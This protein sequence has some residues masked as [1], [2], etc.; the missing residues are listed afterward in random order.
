MIGPTLTLDLPVL[1]PQ[2]RMV[3]T[4]GGEGDGHEGATHRVV[5]ERIAALLGLPFGGACGEG[6]A[7]GGSYLV[8]RAPLCGPLAALRHGIEGEHDLLGSWVHEA[9]MATKAIVHPLVSDEAQAPAG[10]PRLLAR[11]AMAL[12]LRGRTAFCAEDALEAGRE[13]L[14]L[15]PVRLKPAGADGG[16]GQTVVRDSAGLEAAIAALCAGGV[17]AEGL[18]L[19]EDLEDVTTWSVGQLRLPGRTISYWGT[20]SLTV[21][22]RGEPAYGGSSL[23]VVPD[24][25]DALLARPLDAECRDAIRRAIAFDRLA[26][27]HLVGMVASRRNYDVACGRAADGSRRAGVLEQSWR[28]GGATPAEIAALEA[29]VR[30]PH[31]RAVRARCVEIHGASPFVPDGATV[32]Y[33]GDDPELGPLTKYACVDETIEG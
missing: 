21:N 9:W 28:V 18:V 22:N 23:F 27:R 15:G 4:H 31:L 19:E 26:D 1:H 5:A 10:W 7:A 29:F 12:T 30:Q 2:P 24:G 32:Y 8:P 14:R 6:A 11:E 33:R 17:L 13:L 20:Q 25:F 16:R 3:F